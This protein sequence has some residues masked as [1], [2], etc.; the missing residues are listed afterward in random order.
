MWTAEGKFGSLGSVWTMT[1][2]VCEQIQDY[3]APSSG[4]FALI[5]SNKDLTGL[6]GS[7]I[8]T[9]STS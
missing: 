5:E 9:N 8:K 4:G 7:T 3:V 1:W 6:L 2:S